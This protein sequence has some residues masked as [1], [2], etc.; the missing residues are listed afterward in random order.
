MIRSLRVGR[1]PTQELALVVGCA[2]SHILEEAAVDV[3]RT[4]EGGQRAS[5]LEQFQRAHMDLLVST[6]GVRHRG[7]IPGKARRIEN[8]EVKHR[9]QSLIGAGGCFGLEPIEDVAHLELGV[10]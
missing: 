7:P 6:Q 4:A 5:G 3:V 1:N 8:D 10:A 9:H 2:Q